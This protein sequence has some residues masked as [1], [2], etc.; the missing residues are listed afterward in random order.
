MKIEGLADRLNA[1]RPEPAGDRNAANRALATAFAGDGFSAADLQAYHGATAPAAD[2][3]DAMLVEA[4]GELHGILDATQRATLAD[5]I[6]ERGL[7]FLGGKG[8]KHHGKRGG[9][10]HVAKGTERLCAAVACTEEQRVQITELVQAQ[11][12]G[13]QVPEADRAALAQ[14][15]RGESLS[16]EAVTAYLEAAAKARAADMAARDAQTVQLHGLLT[17]PQRAT[18]AE[19]IGE[20]G[21]KALLG[22]GHGKGPRGDHGGKKHRGGKQGKRGEGPQ[23]EAQQFG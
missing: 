18:L 7:P 21:P 19:Q 17:P 5:K 11:P 23:G 16:D 10:D 22:K 20:H 2:E 14:A 6:E 12:E 9:D 1:E 15:F 4:V 8:G 3:L 13:G